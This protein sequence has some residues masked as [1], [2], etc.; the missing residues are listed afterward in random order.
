M[1]P[2]KSEIVGGHVSL[3]NP[4]LLLYRLVL[5]GF[6][7]SEASIYCYGYNISIIV[8][9]RTVHVLEDL[10]YDRGDMCFLQQYLPKEIKSRPVDRDISFKGKIKKINW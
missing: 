1:P 4:G 6:D 5:A 7:C 2:F 3:W 8:Q 9:K 10:A